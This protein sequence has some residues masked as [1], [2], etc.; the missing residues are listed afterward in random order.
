VSSSSRPVLAVLL[1]VPWW[2]ACGADMPA[3]DGDCNARIRYDGVVYRPHNAVNQVAPR[4]EELGTG[5]VVGCGEGASAPRVDEVLVYSVG[6]VSQPIAV[7]AAQGEW[8]GI[9]VAEGLRR[10]DWPS[11]LR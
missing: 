10:T 9:Y 8:E 6:G 5:D 3:G 1:L 4:G 11:A 7:M 2:S